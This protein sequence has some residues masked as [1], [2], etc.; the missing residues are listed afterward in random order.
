MLALA[1][2]NP[3]LALGAERLPAIA[4]LQ[5]LLLDVVARVAVGAN[6]VDG[7]LRRVPGCLTHAFTSRVKERKQYKTLIARE[8][9]LSAPDGPMMH[10]LRVSV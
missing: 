10:A 1:F 3:V 5:V 9:T 2:V 6:V 7:L 8:Q 4:L